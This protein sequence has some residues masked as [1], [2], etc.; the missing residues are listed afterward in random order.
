MDL[1]LLYW[2]DLDIKHFFDDDPELREYSII[3]I[4]GLD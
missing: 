1:V 4:R 2:P 3:N